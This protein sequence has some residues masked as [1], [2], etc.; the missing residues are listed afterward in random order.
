MIVK[1]YRKYIPETFRD[2][3]YDAFLGEFLSFFRNFKENTKSIYIYIFR[4]FLPDTVENKL[5]AFMGRYGLTPFPY[6]FMLKYKKLSFNFLYDKQLELHYVIHSGK[7]LY[8]PK[9]YNERRLYTC[10]SYLLIEQDNQSPHQYLKDLNRLSGK[11][12]L[13]VGTAEGIFSLDAIEIVD[14]VYL[15]ECDELW[16]KALDATFAPWKDK[17]T[18]IPKYVSDRNDEFNI[19]I[20]S[21]LEGKEKSNLFLKMDI[22]GYEQAA[23]R[24][25]ANTLK[26]APDIDFSICTYHKKEDA[27]E[28]EKFLKAYNFEMEQTAGF[29]YFE[30][31]FR[32]AIIRRKI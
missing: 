6:K 13:D 30:G 27:V 20:D 11:T 18:V 29:L 12:I 7:K 23:L 15:F 9:N 14:H 8:F 3:V 19:T 22:E 25:A 28:I 5:Y 24:G 32:K 2:K 1:L 4:F 10:Y 26:K 17:V 31:D 16:I 21:F